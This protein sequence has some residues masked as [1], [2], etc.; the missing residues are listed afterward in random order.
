MFAFASM[1]LWVLLVKARRSHTSSKV[2]LLLLLAGSSSIACKCMMMIPC[3]E[4]L[5][6]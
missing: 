5:L 4:L 3:N 6:S 1:T 2:L